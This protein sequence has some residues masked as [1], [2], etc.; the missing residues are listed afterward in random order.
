MKGLCR[1]CGGRNAAVVA[2]QGRDAPSIFRLRR[3]FRP[4]GV[5]LPN[6]IMGFKRVA[7]LEPLLRSFLNIRLDVP[8][9]ID[10][11]G[12]PSLVGPKKVGGVTRPSTKDC[13]IK[14]TSST[15]RPADRCGPTGSFRRERF[16][17]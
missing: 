9:G 13:L 4:L 15:I 16:W 7:D 11:C 6:V 1:F 10:G 12:L 17:P 5:A 3:L 8:P 14:M 2:Y